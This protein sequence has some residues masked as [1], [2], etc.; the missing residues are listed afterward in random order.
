MTRR[1]DHLGR[2]VADIGAD[3]DAAKENR[4]RRRLTGYSNPTT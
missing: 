4:Y 1:R 3:F 2:R